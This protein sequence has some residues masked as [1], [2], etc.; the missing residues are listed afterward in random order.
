MEVF[1]EMKLKDGTIPK[2]PG[3][4]EL[5][6]DIFLRRGRVDLIPAVESGHVEAGRVNLRED[7]I[8][9]VSCK[10]NHRESVLQKHGLQFRLGSGVIDEPERPT[11]LE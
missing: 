5:S 11:A 9:C 8:A 1:P 7:S 2:L 4:L 6:P 10:A 3:N